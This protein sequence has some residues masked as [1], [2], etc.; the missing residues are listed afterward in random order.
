[1]SALVCQRCLQGHEKPC[2]MRDVCECPSCSPP[3]PK[4]TPLRRPAARRE[5]MEGRMQHMERQVA[6]LWGAL[7]GK[8]SLDADAEMLIP[9]PAP[10][11][12]RPSSLPP[13]MQQEVAARLVVGETLSAVARD[14]DITRDKVRTIRNEMLR[15]AG[16]G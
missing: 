15:R 11:K 10:R 2:L 16:Q 8:V 7:Q 5:Y 4:L 14:L 1:M 13:D 6:L 12:G 9:P 3:K